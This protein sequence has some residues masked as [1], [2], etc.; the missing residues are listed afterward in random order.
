MTL[1]Q[2]A[3]KTVIQNKNL[4]SWDSEPHYTAFG[5]N[6]LEMPEMGAGGV[7]KN[8]CFHRHFWS[9]KNSPITARNP[10]DSVNDIPYP[11]SLTS[12]SRT[13]STRSPG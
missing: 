2:T 5:E 8:K 13:N 10:T 11:L 7:R 3:T 12:P 6:G 4:I 1:P 9:G